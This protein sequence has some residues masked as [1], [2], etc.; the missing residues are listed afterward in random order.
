MPKIAPVIL[1]AF[2]LQLLYFPRM[3]IRQMSRCSDSAGRRW[4]EHKA[5][6]CLFVHWHLMLFLVELSVSWVELSFSKTFLNKKVNR[7]AVNRLLTSWMTEHIPCEFPFPRNG[8]RKVRARLQEAA[9]RGGCER[10]WFT[11]YM[12]GEVSGLL[13]PGHCSGIQSYMRRQHCWSE[14]LFC[15]TSCRRAASS[16]LIRGL[17]SETFT[18]V[19]FKKFEVEARS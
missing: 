19:V 13:H 7:W 14:G 4:R 18:A 16:V 8:S 17:W 9:A 10:G 2:G 5:F 1:V 11:G 15:T 3:L 12:F 6:D